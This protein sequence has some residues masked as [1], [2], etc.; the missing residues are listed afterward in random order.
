MISHRIP[1]IL[2]MTFTKFVSF[3]VAYKFD[4]RLKSM[5]FLIFSEKCHKCKILA[6][7]RSWKILKWSWKRHGH[8][9]E[10]CGNPESGF[11]I[12]A[13]GQ[14]FHPFYL[15]TCKFTCPKLCLLLSPTRFT[16]LFHVS[17]EGGKR[18][19]VVNAFQNLNNYL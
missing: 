10:V 11:R 9:C 2:P 3:F 16:G 13:P 17:C 4:I 6:E 18:N 5:R 7:R 14:V 12:A 19:I 8:F 15:P 1:P